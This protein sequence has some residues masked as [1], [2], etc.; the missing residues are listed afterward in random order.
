MSLFLGMVLRSVLISLFH[1]YLLLHSG[2][3]G[4]TEGAEDHLALRAWHAGNFKSMFPVARKPCNI[5]I[6]IYIYI[7]MTVVLLFPLINEK[8]LYVR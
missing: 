7:Y 2:H 5:Y 8:Q 4:F 1:V 6:Y 3:D